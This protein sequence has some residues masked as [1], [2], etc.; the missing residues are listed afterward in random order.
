M[1]IRLIEIKTEMMKPAEHAESEARALLIAHYQG[2]EAQEPALKIG[3]IAA[4]ARVVR[5]IDRLN[6]GGPSKHVVWLTAG[7]NAEQFETTLISGT[8][9][10]GEDD[11]EYFAQ[12]AGVEP[13]IIEEMSRELSWHDLIVVVKLVGQLLRLKPRVIHTHKSKAGA[14]GRIAALI[15]KWMTPSALWLRPRPCRIVHTFHGH[16]FHSY[17]GPVKTRLFIA[18]ERLLAR[19]CTDCIITISEQQR[20][21]ILERFRIGRAEQFRVVPLGIDFS[22]VSERRGQLRAE[23]GIGDDEALV[24]I[25]GRLSEVKNHALLLEAARR[26]SEGQ[27]HKVRFVVVGDGHLRRKLE[28]LSRKLSIADKVSFIG[29][30]DDAASLYGDMDMV[31]LTSLNEGT[32]LTLIEA[33]ACGRAVAATEVG[34]V[35]DLMGERRETRAGFSIWD[36]GVTAASRDAEGFAQA[37]RF[38]I[39]W[40]ELRREAGARGRAFVRVRFSRERLLSDIEGLYMALIND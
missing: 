32:P 14:A 7:L 1:M 30:R 15:Y 26:L 8:V 10:A 36:H 16:I 22:E 34:G 19:L 13:L 40:P 27:A 18:I 29:F 17:Y 2:R 12:A 6:V 35:V 37:L 20:R 28:N 11:M 3:S 23:L 21:E 5:I 38:L 33:M 25:V 39:E 9:P 4:P 24:G 31:A